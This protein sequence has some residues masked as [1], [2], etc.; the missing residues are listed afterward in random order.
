MA[1][2]QNNNDS[3]GRL[4]VKI[5]IKAVLLFVISFSLFMTLIITL[6]NIFGS[7]YKYNTSKAEIIGMCNRSYSDRNYGD[8]Y[9]ILLL[10]DAYDDQFDVYWEMVDGYNNYIEYVK[11]SEAD[12]KGVADA[13]V[14][15][16]SYKEKLKEC[17]DNCTSD[18][19]KKELEKFA[20]KMK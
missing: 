10:Y 1:A 8:L 6:G 18:R 15:A 19:N 9:D 11:W 7:K 13:A 2:K 4:T 14:M 5:C 17:I 20:N 12:A 3:I 16:S